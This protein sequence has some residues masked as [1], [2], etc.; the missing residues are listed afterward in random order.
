MILTITPNPALDRV[1]IIDA[2][3]PGERIEAQQALDCVGGK[4]FDISVALAG[5][6]VESLAMGILG[7]KNGQLLASLLKRYGVQIDLTWA[8]GETRLAHVIIERAHSRHSHLMTP[9]FQI[10]TTI[11]Q[12]FLSHLRSRSHEADWIAAGGS[13]APGLPA[14]FFAQ[15]V[16]IAHQAGAGSLVDSQG[17]PLRLCLHAKPQ[18]VKLNLAEFCATFAPPAAGALS[19]TG[20]PTQ[21]LQAMRQQVQRYELPALLVTLGARGALA[22]TPQGAYLAAA[23]AQQAL[24]AAGAGDAFSAGLLW[25]L[26]QGESWAE[27][28][29]WAA[30]AGAASVL[31]PAT[32]ELRMEDVLARLPQTDVQTLDS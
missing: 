26:E 16:Q 8:P 19:E 31:T 11:L 3:Q 24:N 14:D 17:E 22:L 5:L 23:P 7:G 27:A 30:A 25:R 18:V 29:R 28:L 4:G 6:G 21:L 2:F 32:G 10:S 12:T 13:L 15:V 1:L 9:A 20:D